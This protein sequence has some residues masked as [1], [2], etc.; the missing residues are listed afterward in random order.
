MEQGHSLSLFFPFSHPLE[1]GL[2]SFPNRYSALLLAHVCACVAGLQHSALYRFRRFAV[3]FPF[4]LLEVS[5]HPIQL[6][7][8]GVL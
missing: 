8:S 4:F 2:E 5:L 1:V 6:E 7:T 3:G